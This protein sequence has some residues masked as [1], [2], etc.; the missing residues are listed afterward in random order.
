M[1]DSA[2]VVIVLLRRVAAV[3]LLVVVVRNVNRSRDGGGGED[4]RRCEQRRILKAARHCRQRK[5][6]AGRG[7][8]RRSRIVVTVRVLRRLVEREMC[9]D[10][11]RLDVSGVRLERVR[12]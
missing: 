1:Q 12:R 2:A 10:F 3:L 5:R 11:A 4:G 9:D 8:R 7:L 6:C